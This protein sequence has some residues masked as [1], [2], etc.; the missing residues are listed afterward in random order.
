MEKEGLAK[1]VMRVGQKQKR[2]RQKERKDKVEDQEIDRQLIFNAQPTMMVI[3]RAK[4]NKRGDI[5]KWYQIDSPEIPDRGETLAIPGFPFGD[6][7]TSAMLR[8]LANA[9]VTLLF[10][11][12]GLQF[13]LFNLYQIF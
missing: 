12:M 1:E 10:S 11:Q 9:A 7:C 4:N 5:E 8:C 6:S 3:I 2:I 13:T